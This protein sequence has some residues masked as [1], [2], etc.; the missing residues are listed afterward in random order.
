MAEAGANFQYRMFAWEMQRGISGA[1]QC[2]QQQVE[3]WRYLAAEARELCDAPQEKGVKASAATW[4]A[5]EAKG[6]GKQG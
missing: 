2:S 3:F 4:E 1:S 6:G 5:K